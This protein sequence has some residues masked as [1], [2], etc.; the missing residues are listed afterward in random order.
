M[1]HN[2]LTIMICGAAIISGT[3]YPNAEEVRC[4]NLLGDAHV[5]YH[6]CETTSSIDVA[7]NNNTIQL[8]P[9]IANIVRCIDGH[10]QVEAAVVA[11]LSPSS[12][13]DF[14]ERSQLHI[15]QVMTKNMHTWRIYQ[16]SRRRPFTDNSFDVVFWAC[17]TDGKRT[18]AS[19]KELYRFCS[20]FPEHIS[21]N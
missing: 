19:L 5:Q 7:T 8:A 14:A 2:M 16:Y 4:L 1:F 12:Y 13:Y 18:S 10:V 21:T 15:R 17:R 6:A 9:G 20:E 11:K 3:H